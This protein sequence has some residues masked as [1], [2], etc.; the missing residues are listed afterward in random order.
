MLNTVSK[1]RTETLIGLPG[2][3]LED[4]EVGLLIVRYNATMQK[5][6][7]EQICA[8]FAKMIGSYARKSGI[9]PWEDAAQEMWCS[10]FEKVIPRYTFAKGRVFGFANKVFRNK[11][12]DM[13]RKVKKLQLQEVS[14]ENMPEPLA[15]EYYSPHLYGVW[16]GI[17]NLNIDHSRKNI[18]K[19]ALYSYCIEQIDNRSDIVKAV[20]D[21]LGLSQNEVNNVLSNKSLY[22]NFQACVLGGSA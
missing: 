16:V 19:Y 20:S 13:H 22:K 12:C 11:I 21:A 6:L 14:L 8:V 18:L 3:D 9:R 1:R 17:G 5:D 10:L 7:L 4:F 15:E 2:I